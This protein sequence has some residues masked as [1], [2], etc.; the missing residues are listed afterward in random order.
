M[1][2]L[3]GLLC[4]LLMASCAKPPMFTEPQ[5]H[6]GVLVVDAASGDTLIQQNA[7]RYFVPASTTKLITLITSLHLIPEQMPGLAYKEVGDSLFIWGLG[8]PSV[9]LKDFPQPEYA[10]LKNATAKTIVFSDA[11]FAAK[12]RGQG[13]MWDDFTEDY[14]AELSSLPLY[15][16]LLTVSDFAITPDYFRPHVSYQIESPMAIS[17]AE[18]SNEFTFRTSET[19]TRQIPFIT[20]GELTATLLSEELR[21]E[22]VYKAIPMPNDV[23]VLAG[24]NRDELM[25]PMMHHSDNMLAEQLLLTASGGISNKLDGSIARNFALSEFLKDIPDKPRWVDGSG[26]SRYNLFTPAD[27]VYEI[28]YLHQIEPQKTLDYLP[29]NSVSNGTVF[30]FM[31][32]HPG[33]IA[34]K[35]GSMSGVYNLTGILT[36]KS[37]RQLYFAVMNNNFTESVSAV[38]QKTEAYLTR[39]WEKY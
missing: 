12:T 20:S 17:R 6:V 28:T 19:G 3:L 22:V 16:N 7:H 31:S 35:S 10:F 14:Q 9:L 34:A 11:N 29:K 30:R 33:V 21:R 36:A 5:H 37:G 32:E 2:N 26:L 39:I 4:L 15:G 18:G 23:Q 8:S 27:L 38:R 25:I 13:W 24:V 1:K